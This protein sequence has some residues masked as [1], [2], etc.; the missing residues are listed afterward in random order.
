MLQ[1]NLL[2]QGSLHHIFSHK[3]DIIHIEIQIFLNSWS[4]LM[5]PVLKY[6]GGKSKEIPKFINYVPSDYET[7]YEPF[8]G[9]GAL[10]FYLEPERAVINDQ[11]GR[12]MDFYTCIQNNY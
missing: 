3:Y 10:Y 9:G 7:Y 5:K 4:V 1:N 6:R 2:S 12:L 11:N 8:F